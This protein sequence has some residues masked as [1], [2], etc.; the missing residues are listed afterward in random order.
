[1]H[2]WAQA[3]SSR[4][5]RN[6]GINTD[7]STIRFGSGVFTKVNGTYSILTA[8]PSASVSNVK[9]QAGDSNGYVNYDVATLNTVQTVTAIKTH[10]ANIVT[11][12]AVGVRGTYTDGAIRNLVHINAQNIVHVGDALAPTLLHGSLMPQVQVGAGAT[13]SIADTGTDQIITGKKIFNRS[14]EAFQIKPLEDNQS[15][16]IRGQK[17]DNT[18]HWYIR[19]RGGG[20]R[21]YFRQPTFDGK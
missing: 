18:V 2:T 10:T 14:S 7:A 16:F 12:N 13:Y 6:D 11:A 1:M 21:C 20:F 15:C 8:G 3:N 5:F 4:S 19:I 17:A 9:I